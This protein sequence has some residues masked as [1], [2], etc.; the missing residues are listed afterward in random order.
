MTD[1]E[2]ILQI[3]PAFRAL[4]SKKEGMGTLRFDPQESEGL[5][6]ENGEP[7]GLY[8]ALS[9]GLQGMENPPACVTVKGLGSFHY[10]PFDSAKNRRMEGKIVL[11]TGAAQGL[12]KDIASQ[13]AADGAKVVCADLN[14]AGAEALAEELCEKWGKNAALGLRC[15]VGSQEDV[16]A[17]VSETVRT[18]GGIDVFVNNAGIVRSGSLETMTEGDFELSMKVNYTAYFL[19]VQAVSAVMKLQKRFFPCGLFDIVQINSKSGLEGSN[20]NFAYAGSKA[21]GIGLTKSF[22]LE[23]APYGIKV[24]A[25]CP[26]NY[27]NGPLWSDPE[28][29]LFVQYLKAGKV[30]GATTVEEV[31]AYYE[32]KVPLGRGCEAADVVRAVYYCVEQAYETGQA[33]PVTGGQIMLS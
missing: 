31:R 16:S 26:G 14:G 6:L 20:K 21:G 5:I 3:A 13:M 2:K 23:L 11:V 4:L 10:T 28:K 9:E 19:G 18:Y 33:I 22:A 8:A 29:G 25:V 24:N 1:F 17:A 7:E 15:N 30:P 27:L 12:G 32:S